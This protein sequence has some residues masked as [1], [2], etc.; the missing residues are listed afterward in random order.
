MGLPPQEIEMTY[1]EYTGGMAR[2]AEATD[3]TTR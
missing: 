3:R 1:G 2:V